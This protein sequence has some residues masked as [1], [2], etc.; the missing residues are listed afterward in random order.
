MSSR[1]S[2]FGPTRVG[3]NDKEVSVPR[4]ASLYSGGRD[5]ESLHPRSTSTKAVQPKGR[6]RTRVDHL[7]TLE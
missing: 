4:W 3:G 6:G 1:L 7:F 5:G 2:S